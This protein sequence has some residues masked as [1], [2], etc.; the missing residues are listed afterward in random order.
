[1]PSTQFVLTT[2]PCTMHAAHMAHAA[3]VLTAI[4]MARSARVA[5]NKAFFAGLTAAS[6]C[7]TADTSSMPFLAM[8]DPLV[9]AAARQLA[10]KAAHDSAI[11]QVRCTEMLHLL[12]MGAADRFSRV[13]GSQY[14]SAGGG[15]QYAVLDEGPAHVTQLDCQWTLT[16]G[17]CRAAMAH[18]AA[19]A[20]DAGT[21]AQSGLGRA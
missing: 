9:V 12:F 10:S 19:K 20:R 14:S 6:G 16:G 11:L 15:M 8:G 13:K 18:W 17:G 5:A 3:Q 4:E 21:K 2:F 1:M 7:A